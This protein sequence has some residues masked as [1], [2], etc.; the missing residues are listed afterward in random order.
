MSGT[1]GHELPPSVTALLDAA[2][3][4]TAKKDAVAAKQ[5]LK[6]ALAAVAFPTSYPHVR[7]P[8]VE[9]LT[10]DQ[11]AVAES[12]AR[13][14][15]FAPWEWVP[16]GE[17]ARRWL[18]IDPPGPLETPVDHEGAR[19]PLWRALCLTQDGP[20]V[21][22]I[23]ATLPVPLR[24]EV[25]AAFEHEVWAYRIHPDPGS[26]W[27]IASSIGS[28]GRDWALARLA[29]T[30]PT[31]LEDFEGHAVLGEQLAFFALVRAGHPIDPAWDLYL[32]IGT[33]V[34]VE[35][36]A[37][38]AR[39]LPL[40]RLE[41][42]A[43]ALLGNTHGSH[44]I[45]LGL[46]ILAE[47]DSPAIARFVWTTSERSF[48]HHRDAERKTLAAIGETKPGVGEV[49]AS[50]AKGAPK[51]RT[52]VVSGRLAPRSES[53]LSKLQAAQLIEAG[54]KWDR[55]NLPVARRLS[56][57][58]NDEAALGAVLEHVTLT[59]NGK[60]AFEAWLY[61]GDS[62]T[63]F[64]AGTTKIVAQRIQSGI[65]LEGKK[66]DPALADALGRVSE[67][68]DAARPLADVRAATLAGR[69][70]KKA[71]GKAKVE[72]VDAPKAVASPKKKTSKKTT[73]TKKAPTKKAPPKKKT[74]TKKT[75]K[76]KTP[77]KE[78][79]PKRK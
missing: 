58:E 77:T 3:R 46:A 71:G 34:P 26:A 9:T 53:D 17:S 39:V 7:Y 35:I 75:A 11:R 15:V 31:T 29:A 68:K 43:P 28:E 52:L 36:T 44:A 48:P 41:A 56:C 6:D 1:S 64:T 19:I 63:F 37:E 57:D 54:K 60:P 69:E 47:H 49:V 61:A 45:Q 73:T 59:E 10:P 16:R 20:A 66:K 8:L 24:L 27:T 55:K 30:E 62:G 4:A 2:R 22:P 42:V 23:V 72:T 12:I 78:A 74:T 76:K 18:G 70:A 50:F 25:L 5:A 65:Q 40:D 67:S 21:P 14:D 32:P 79:V 33:E 38:C 13:M 51:K